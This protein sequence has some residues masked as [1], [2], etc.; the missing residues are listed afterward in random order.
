MQSDTYARF[1]VRLFY[2][3][4]SFNT[5]L[6]PCHAGTLLAFIFFFPLV[7]PFRHITLSCFYTGFRE[8]KIGKNPIYNPINIAL[9]KT[10]H[11]RSVLPMRHFSRTDFEL[12]NTLHEDY[13]LLG[14]DA[15]QSG[16]SLPI[17]YK[18]L[19]F[20]SSGQ[21]MEVTRFS[22]TSVTIYQTTQRHILAVN[23]IVTSISDYRQGLVW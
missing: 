23:K 18:T 22:K 17:C 16:R 6:S 10:I 14:D 3:N 19:L 21:K 12:Q 13:R 15:V 7:K 9:T 4:N 8:N 11:S 2:Y 20:P 1:L 5:K